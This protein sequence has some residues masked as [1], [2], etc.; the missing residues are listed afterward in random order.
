[1]RRLRQ[2][3]RLR[4]VA[5][6]LALI[7]QLTSAVGLVVRVPVSPIPAKS[8]AVHVPFKPCCC[9]PESNQPCRCGSCADGETA[10]P[11]DDDRPANLGV[12]LTAASCSAKGPLL[13]MS[14][15]PAV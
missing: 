6:L 10:L 9:Y 13:A 3:V 2:F 11:E 12:V 5:L 4:G 14:L 15:P 1:M 7:G 8:T